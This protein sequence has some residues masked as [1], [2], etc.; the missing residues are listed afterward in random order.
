MVNL[1]SIIYISFNMTKEIKFFEIP[2]ERFSGKIPFIVTDL[3]QEMRRRNCEKVVGLFRLNGSDVRCKQLIEELNKGRVT[4]FSHITDIHTIAT[5]LKRYFRRMSEHDPLIPFTIAEC[6]IALMEID[7]N[8]AEPQQLKVMKSLIHEN[9]NQCRKKILYYLCEFLT[10]IAENES[11]NQMS[12]KNLSICIAPNII[13]S[14]HNSGNAMQESGF[15]N[16]AF[17]LLLTHYKEMIDIELTNEDFCDEEDI[18]QI[19]SPKINMVNVK[20]L[21]VRCKLRENSL[22]PYVPTCRVSKN[23]MF[24]RPTKKPVALVDDDDDN[25]D[26]DTPTTKR[27]RM[28][29][30]FNSVSMFAS[31]SLDNQQSKRHSANLENIE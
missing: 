7:S 4:D 13:V 6:F 3:I 5:V 26:G 23:E 21:I 14:D 9:L 15:V 2:P 28:T 16:S 18:A 27:R 11:S 19:C 31:L 17:S 20:H 30:I 24:K 29:Q 1:R 22:I 12:V 8:D 25:G 10:F